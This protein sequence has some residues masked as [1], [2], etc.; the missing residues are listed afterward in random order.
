MFVPARG[1]R[2]LSYLLAFLSRNGL[3]PR[4]SASLSQ[5]HGCRITAI[6]DFINDLVSR[7]VAYELGKLEGVSRSFDAGFS[8]AAIMA[9]NYGSFKSSE[10]ET[11]PL[12]NGKLS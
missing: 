11:D 12:P 5:S 1:C 9:W 3:R 10:I 8:H 2:F 6:L 7:Y 4:S